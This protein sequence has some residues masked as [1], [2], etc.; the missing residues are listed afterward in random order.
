MTD[1]AKLILVGITAFSAIL[2]QDLKKHHVLPN[3]QLF[4]NNG[5][6]KKQNVS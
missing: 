2:L 6:W 4:D 1:L 5:D 3:L